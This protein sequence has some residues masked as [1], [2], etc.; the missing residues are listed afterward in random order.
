MMERTGQALVGCL[1]LWVGLAGLAGAKSAAA[2]PTRFVE[3]ERFATSAATQGVAVDAEHFYAIGTR[4][5]EKY[6]RANGGLVATW[7]AGDDPRV[8]HLNGGIVVGDTLFCAHSNYPGI[9]MRSSIL[10]FDAASLRLRDVRELPLAPG[11]LTWLDWRGGSWWLAFAHYE[12]R[13]GV[14]DKGPGAS[15]VV[16]H[17]AGWN[18]G[19]ALA[20]PG[21]VVERF[22]AH[23]S[24]GGGFGP[25]GLLYVTGHDAAELHALRVPAHGDTLEWVATVPAPIA[26][27]GIAWDRA[28]PAS[29]WGI[30]R[31]HRQVRR[32]D[33]ADDGFMSSK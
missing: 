11:S 15:R 16:Q 17:D 29:L 33:A 25:D 2:P 27:Q 7:D 20:F 1:L 12:G 22:G 6:A 28:P 14:P 4:S 3:V 13:G 26:G 32:L 9:P 18:P 31:G 23:S 8:I 24:S 19:R 10:R 30:V 5:I 21:E